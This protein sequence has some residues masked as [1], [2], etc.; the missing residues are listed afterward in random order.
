MTTIE[1]TAFSGEQG[2]W[3][4]VV[5]AFIVGIGGLVVGVISLTKAHQAKRAAERANDIASAA[6][7]I[8]VAANLLSEEANQISR[9]NALLSAEEHDVDWQC[10]W[11]EPGL[12]VATNGGRD[13]ATQVRIQVT[14][15][16]ETVTAESTFVHHLGKIVLEFPRALES[17]KE[18]EEA[19]LSFERQ[20]RNGPRLTSPVSI[21]PP[22]SSNIHSIR[23][24]ILWKTKLG[25]PKSYIKSF[26][27]SLEP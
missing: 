9:Q 20:A 16:D 17:W 26:L 22:L 7:T 14:V 27:S 11:I 19:R 25:T 21:F 8:S 12:Y 6:N 13:T 10:D 5:V 18:E 1:M 15:D 2:T 3:A 4:G 24:R 23:N